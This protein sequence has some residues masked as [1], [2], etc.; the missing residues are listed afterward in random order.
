MFVCKA[1]FCSKYKTL[2]CETFIFFCFY[3][4]VSVSI[5]YSLSLFLGFRSSRGIKI[6]PCLVEIHPSCGKTEVTSPEHSLGQW[7]MK[8]HR[9]PDY[10]VLPSTVPDPKDYRA[11]HLRPTL[12]QEC[13]K[14]VTVDNQPPSKFP[15]RAFLSG[16]IFIAVFWIWPKAEK[17]LKLGFS[18]LRFTEFTGWQAICT[19]SSWLC[20]V[21]GLTYQ[22]LFEMHVMQRFYRQWEKGSHYHWRL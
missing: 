22:E 15:L 4:L 19:W 2:S 1:N 9:Y 21:S 17:S 10:M 18:S 16:F 7:D 20:A 14:F 5:C 11:L 6:A 12:P 13:Q 3:I 8:L